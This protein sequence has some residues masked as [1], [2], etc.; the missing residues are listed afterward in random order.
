MLLTQIL[1]A[2]PLINAIEA[3]ESG[4]NRLARSTASHALG[5][6]QVTPVVVDDVNRVYHLKLRH[7]D[8]TDPHRSRL[9]F[10]RYMD[11]YATVERLGRD[12]TD[13]DRA[14]IWRHGPDG[15]KRKESGYWTRIQNLLTNP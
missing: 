4:G 10:L 11:M 3:V 5:P 14:L 8:M 2:T 1:S 7:S 15:W 13:R 6:L 12:A 9:V